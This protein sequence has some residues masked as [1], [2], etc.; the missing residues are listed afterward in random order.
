VTLKAS[1]LEA[2]LK[3]LVEHSLAETFVSLGNGLVQDRIG[4][5]V[6][7]ENLVVGTVEWGL[8]T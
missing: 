1:H 2:A 5:I 6:G 3:P 8:R 4:G 7:E